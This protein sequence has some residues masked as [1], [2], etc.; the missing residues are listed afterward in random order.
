MTVAFDPNPSPKDRNAALGGLILGV[1]STAIGLLLV[2]QRQ[3][4]AAQRERDRQRQ[5]EL[6]FLHMV[7]ARNGRV[8]AME[9]AIAHQLTLPEAKAFLDRK[10]VELNAEFE[11]T[12]DG[13]TF[14][15]FPQS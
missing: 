12:E 1:P 6:A 7:Q 15:R 13:S 11:V 8:S 2:R 5:A 10:A 4:V 14:Y 9:Y 3:Q